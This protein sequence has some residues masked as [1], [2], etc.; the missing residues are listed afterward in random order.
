MIKNVLNFRVYKILLVI[1][2]SFHVHSA[3]KYS[4]PDLSISHLVIGESV[5]S[6]FDP[7]NIKLLVWNIYK[8]QKKNWSKDFISLAPK[9]DLLLLQEGYLNP[10]FQE[11]LYFL[12][13]YQFEFGISFV[14]EEEGSVPTGTA[15]GSKVRPF[16]SGLLRSK[17]LEPVIDTPKTITY[18]F[19]PLKGISEKMLVLNIHALNFTS[20]ESF[21]RQI[22]D[23]CELIKTHKGPV[24]FAGDFNTR[25]KNRLKFL[26]DQLQPLGLKELAF[27]D[28]DRMTFMGNPLDH[29]FV[30]SFLVRDSRVLKS[31][32]SSDHKP[33]YIELSLDR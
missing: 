19:Y 30:R 17:D 31:I 10:V 15:L 32:E 11:V 9:A 20:Q 24:V 29:V 14:Y 8:G 16:H 22:L 33:L 13:I 26:R 1:L 2:F 23:A 21:E 5:E 27:V 28:D 12:G 3:S 6:Q 4:I 25:T 18:G 7:Q